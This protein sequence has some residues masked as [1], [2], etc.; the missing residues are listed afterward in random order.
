MK[1]RTLVF[2]GVVLAAGGAAQSLRAASAEDA[3]A[4]F[5]ALA[6]PDLDG[7]AQPLSAW[8]GK[9]LVVNFWATWCGPCVQEMPQLDTLHKK[10]PGIQF[11]GIGIDSA[12]NMRKFVQKVVVSYPLLVAGP[13]GIDV[14]RALGNAPGALPF[15][16]VFGADGRIKRKVLGAVNVADMTTL[17]DTLAA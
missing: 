13:G 16:V 11:A 7:H 17:L 2:G 4:N 12:D 5:F 1:R 15:T 14:M 9:P 3:G 10:Y 8:K 6:Y